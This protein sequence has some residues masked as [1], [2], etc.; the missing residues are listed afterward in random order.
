MVAGLAWDKSSTSN[1]SLIPGASVIRSP[2]ARHRTLESSNTVLRFST[3]SVSTGPSRTS[4]R[5]AW[6]EWVLMTLTLL[7][8]IEPDSDIP[9][10]SWLL[11]N[12]K[13]KKNLKY[14]KLKALWNWQ[15][16][17]V[18]KPDLVTT[19]TACSFQKCRIS[20]WSRNFKF[21]SR[22]TLKTANTD[23]PHVATIMIYSGPSILRSP[24]DQENVVWYCRWF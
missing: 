18:V 2:S 19:E 1:S 11:C 3:H 9:A 14:N 17:V 21:E 4:H 10:S 7:S 16:H 8:A 22:L 6:S 13:K 5:H 24:W 15:K 20:F 12:Q 23:F